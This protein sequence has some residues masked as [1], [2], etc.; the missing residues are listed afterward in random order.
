MIRST[1]STQFT[2]N[3]RQWS[4]ST[5]R[6]LTSLVASTCDECIEIDGCTLSGELPKS[7][8]LDCGEW[9]WEG[10]GDS[11]FVDCG[12]LSSESSGIWNQKERGESGYIIEIVPVQPLK[13]WFVCSIAYRQNVTFNE[14]I[15]LYRNA[16]I[17]KQCRKR[18][19]QLDKR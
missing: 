17:S 15:L 10:S 8:C 2:F 5:K 4:N 3:I 14:Q 16:I 6:K 7:P 11:A 19:V 18:Q 12:G 1:H 9:K 13:K